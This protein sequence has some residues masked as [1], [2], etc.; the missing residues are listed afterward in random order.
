MRLFLL[1]TISGLLLASC[2][3]VPALRNVVNQDALN[4]AY[5]SLLPSDQLLDPT[6][7][8]TVAEATLAQLEASEADLRRRAEALRQVNLEN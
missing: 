3:D 4:A 7:D 1:I 8:P 6:L 2:V 5:P